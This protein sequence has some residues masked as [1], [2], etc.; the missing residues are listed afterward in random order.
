MADH[1]DRPNRSLGAGSRTQL[2]TILRIFDAAVNELAKY[3]VIFVKS[4]PEKLVKE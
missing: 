4:Q 2:N 3:Y 1:I